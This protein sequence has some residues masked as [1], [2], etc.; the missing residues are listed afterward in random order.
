MYFNRDI[1]DDELS[2]EVDNNIENR[3]ENEE[4]DE[5]VVELP[6][7]PLNSEEYKNDR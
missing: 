4:S 3:E 6:K 1:W 7:A 2:N 5:V